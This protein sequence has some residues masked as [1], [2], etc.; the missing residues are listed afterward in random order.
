[1]TT[2]IESEFDTVI[3]MARFDIARLGFGLRQMP[4]LVTVHVHPGTGDS[5]TVI[6]SLR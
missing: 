2:G 1:V 4:Q 6:I 3:M 5:I